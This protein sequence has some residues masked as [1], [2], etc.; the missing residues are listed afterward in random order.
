MSKLCFNGAVLLLRHYPFGELV[1]KNDLFCCDHGTAVR[2]AIVYSLLT[3]CIVKSQLQNG[4][5]V[6]K[7]HT[8]RLILLHKRD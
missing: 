5:I 2:A 4:I 6:P 1:P 3:S 7:Y 8:Y